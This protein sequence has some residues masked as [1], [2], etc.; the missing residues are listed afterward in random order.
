MARFQN[1][2]TGQFQKFGG[3]RQRSTHQPRPVVRSIQQWIRCG[4]VGLC[5]ML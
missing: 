2:I 5:W 4:W 1:E 3:L